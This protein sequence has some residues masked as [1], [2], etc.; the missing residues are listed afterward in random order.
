MAIVPRRKITVGGNKR[1]SQD[2]DR[3]DELMVKSRLAQ[4]NSGMSF[5]EGLRSLSGAWKDRFTYHLSYIV[6]GA[7]NEGK[8]FRSPA[9]GSTLNV[10]FCPLVICFKL[11]L[12]TA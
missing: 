5:T 7:V 6:Q 11:V 4:R 2:R 3:Y 9:C 12:K 8:F 1:G 10:G